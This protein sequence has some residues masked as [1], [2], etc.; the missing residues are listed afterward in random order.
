[1]MQMQ[2]AFWLKQYLSNRS[3]GRLDEGREGLVLGLNALE[4]VV[5]DEDG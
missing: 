2:L 5:E 3:I 4:V 1:M